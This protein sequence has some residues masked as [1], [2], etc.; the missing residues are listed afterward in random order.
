MAD[1]NPFDSLVGQ[2]QSQTP[3]PPANTAPSTAPPV[4][5]SNPFDALVGQ[6]GQQQDTQAPSGQ[7]I[8]DGGAINLDNPND[9]VLIK[10]AKGVASL[11]AGAGEAGLDTLAGGA[12]LLGMHGAEQ[13]LRAEHDKLAGQNANN[14]TL[15]TVGYGGETLAE[16]MLGDEALKGLGF[17]DKLEQVAKTAK[18]LEKSPKLMA[19]LKVGANAAAT[20][21]AQTAL[22]TPGTL[23]ERAKQGAETGLTTGA[24]GGVLGLTGSY[25]SDVLSQGAKA[26]KNVPDIANIAATAKSSPEVIQALSE[27]IGQTEDALHQDYENGINDLKGRLAGAELDPQANPIQ[28]AAEKLR[29]KPIPGDHPATA[30]IKK[31][32]GEGLDGK[33]QAILDV[34]ADGN[35]PA[36]EAARDE[37]AAER[38]KMGPKPFIE[39]LETEPEPIPARPYTI[40]DLIDMRQ[41]IRKAIQS[42]EPGDTNARTLR[43]LLWNADTKSSPIDDA[44]DKLAQQSSDPTAVGD[45]QSLRNNYRAH[46]NDYDDPLIKKIRE[47]KID[48]A[49]S[50]YVGLNRT[51]ASLPAASKITYNTNVLRNI[52]GDDGLHQFGREVFDTMLQNATTNG[53]FDP[54]RFTA[55]WNRVSEQSKGDQGI[56][57]VKDAA[58][59][60]AK[61]AADAKSAA[62]IQHLTRVGLFTGAGAAG[63]HFGGLGALLGMTVAEGGGIATG[64]DLLNWIATHPDSWKVWGKLGAAAPAVAPA[65][66]AATGVAGQV[67]D[68]ANQPDQRVYQS[69][70]SG[71]AQ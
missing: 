48:D 29:T 39:P 11:A 12:N 42:Y 35:D 69:A 30:Q 37:E 58:N 8:L 50:Q 23:V 60:M 43:S 33:T 45:Y 65:V 26:A 56:F 24:V 2:G 62:M 38:A 40:D 57:N 9:N 17:A 19:A 66:T 32:A 44:I 13:A 52:L 67:I 25:L 14:P 47:G 63:F 6:G 53:K 61:L 7:G 49:A 10:G 36:A 54:A 31:S 18:I 3:G 20:Q 34:L 22:R 15:N 59:G 70:S 64:R 46:I 16:F 5:S 51:G 4:T 55:L 28:A 1:Q 41:N 21:G 68:K 71:L 27:R